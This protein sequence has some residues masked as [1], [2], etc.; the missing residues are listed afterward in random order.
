MV[1]PDRQHTAGALDLTTPFRQL[2]P[3]G[4][5]LPS[6]THQAARFAWVSVYIDVGGDRGHVAGNRGP[7]SM[8]QA[9]KRRPPAQGLGAASALLLS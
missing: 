8:L 2:R 3:L 9:T 7:P 4:W 6:L 1:S 5:L